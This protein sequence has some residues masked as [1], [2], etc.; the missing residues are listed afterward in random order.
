MKPVLRLISFVGLA[1]TVGPAFLVFAGV[2][3]WD[4]YATWMLVG[5]LLWFLSAPLWM[6]HHEDGPMS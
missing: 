1:L 5:T 2:M 6:A 3:T 4:R